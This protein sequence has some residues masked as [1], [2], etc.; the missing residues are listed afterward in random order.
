[1]YNLLTANQSFFALNQD[2]LIVVCVCV[3]LPVSVVALIVW[4]ARNNTNKKAEIMTKAIEAGA[5]IP[6]DFWDRMGGKTKNGRK[7]EESTI[8]GKLLK[9]LRSGIIVSGLGLIFTIAG[10]TKINIAFSKE[11][12]AFAGPIMLVVGIA[13]I[14]YYIVASKK[15]ADRIQ[16]EEE[17]EIDKI[18]KR[19]EK[20]D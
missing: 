8:K 4:V 14:V 16:A 11:L 13:N 18:L 12:L 5:T 1:M 7:M 17:I 20:L 3:I 19:K 2:L 6:D 9:S 15:M 10:L